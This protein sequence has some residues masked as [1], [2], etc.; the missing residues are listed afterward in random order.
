MN[1][2]PPITATLAVT[3]GISIL[4]VSPRSVSNTSKI[5]VVHPRRKKK[6]PGIAGDWHRSVLKIRLRLDYDKDVEEF[7]NG[8]ES[9]ASQMKAGVR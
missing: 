1:P 6:S 2:D 4:F 8:E 7:I 3:V 9:S 5:A